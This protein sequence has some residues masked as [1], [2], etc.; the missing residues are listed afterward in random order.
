MS[1]NSRQRLAAAITLISQLVD[2]LVPGISLSA[3]SL[4]FTP[5]ICQSAQPSQPC[6]S[7]ACWLH[8]GNHA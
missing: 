2:M 5:H 7:E 6:S 4:L 1:S 3:A 8:R